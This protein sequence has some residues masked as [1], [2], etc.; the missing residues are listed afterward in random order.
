VLA[1]ALASA[2]LGGF[3][4]SHVAATVPDK[5]PTVFE[6]DLAK[7]KTVLIIDVLK[8]KIKEVTRMIMARHPE[9]DAREAHTTIPALP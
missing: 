4:A 2:A 5:R 6:Q 7:N 1:S 3:A 9:L 8:K